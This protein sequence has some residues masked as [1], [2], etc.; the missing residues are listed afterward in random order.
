MKYLSAIQAKFSV[1]AKYL[2]STIIRDSKNL[3]CMEL[4]L[5]TKT[6]DEN[7]LDCF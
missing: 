2:Y 1:L 4:A 6:Q 7:F 3:S 5:N